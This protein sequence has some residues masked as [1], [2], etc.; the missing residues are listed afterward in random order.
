[1][2]GHKISGGG[3]VVNRNP[4]GGAGREGCNA[5]T[6][7]RHGAVNADGSPP[8]APADAVRYR[9]NAVDQARY[10]LKYS[11]KAEEAIR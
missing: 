4:L 10:R 11:G 2:P 9:P 8:S 1:M 5:E 6:T 3:P 7:S